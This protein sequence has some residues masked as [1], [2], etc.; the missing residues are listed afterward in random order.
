M[1][2][3]AGWLCEPSTPP[4]ENIL[5][6]MLDAM[7]HRGPDDRGSYI[8]AAAGLA[9]G[10]LRLSIIDLTT[11]SRQPMRDEAT[12]VTLAY[13]GEVY[14]FRTLRAELEGR[15]HR[16]RS[17]GDTEVV[18]RAFLEWGTAS[19]AR[20][21]GM[22]ALALWDPRTQTLHVARDAMGM[23]P[24]YIARIPGGAVFAS[25]VKALKA[26]PGLRLTPTERGLRQYLEF[27]YVFDT[28]A[29]IF[30]GVR[31]LP[32]G[33]HATLRV[34]GDLSICRF[35]EP[36]L[37]DPR[38]DRDEEAR[39]SELSSVLETVV[40]EHLIADVRVGLLLSGGL[41][42]SLIA[43]I[44]AR[45]G[46]LLTLSMGFSDSSIDERPNARLV[47]E[48]IGSHHL[49]IEITPAEVMREVSSGAWVFD[50]LFADWGTITT[51]LMYRACR[52][53]G[54]KAVIVG[55][56]ADELFGGYDIFRVPERLGLLEMFRLYQ[57]YAGRRHGR[58]FGEFRRVVN[59]YQDL[60]HGEAFDA[61]RHFE[62]CRQL[63]NQFV[64]KVD[65]AS[66][67]ESVEARAP[68]LDHRVAR[69][70]LRTPK[71]WLLRGA[72]T[73]YL[74]RAAARREPTLPTTTTGR[75]K[76]GAPLAAT[77]MDD[78]REFRSF[79]RE[80][81]LDGTWA[82]RLGLRDAMCAYFNDGLQGYAWP[83]EISIFRNLAWRLL[84]LELWAPHYVSERAA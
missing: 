21:G 47:A 64:M 28:N 79:A 42:S 48:A 63:P 77:W 3:L 7:P 26:V 59:A 45:R 6:Q 49:E 25:E 15:G 12:G 17:T 78:H 57:R 66:M 81:L 72:E 27:G 4:A 58:L 82:R 19:F 74:L 69:V 2:G 70:A 34:G 36:P 83:A 84:L 75:L 41:D 5:S 44:A 9:L 24:L 60:A 67:A 55:E 37:P 54:V 53:R 62:C 51:Q 1:C 16:F 68:F 23:K 18:L 71:R 38:D 11:A 73:K 22:F 65:K 33:C 76:F 80:R 40:G 13:N 30:D 29:T 8:D 32:P 39:V 43:A 20:F 46:A 14:N 52:E 61:V 56:G 10:H 35:F 50:D 31:K